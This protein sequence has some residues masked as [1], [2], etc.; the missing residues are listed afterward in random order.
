MTDTVIITEI[1]TLPNGAQVLRAESGQVVL[2]RSAG[3]HD[4]QMVNGAG[5]PAERKALGNLYPVRGHISPAMG[6]TLRTA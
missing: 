4:W 3:S 5:T 6:Y 1:A 2:I